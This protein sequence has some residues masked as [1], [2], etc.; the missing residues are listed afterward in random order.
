MGAIVKVDTKEEARRQMVVVDKQLSDVVTKLYDIDEEAKALREVLR[1]TKEAKR[2]KEIAQ[3]KKLLLE[4]RTEMIGQRKL[5][6]RIL[7]KMKI[8]MPDTK[9]TRLLEKNEEISQ[10]VE[11]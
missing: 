3:T 7:A 11:N 9:L 1:Q 8:E 6:M 2:L 4:Q 10:Y 5:I